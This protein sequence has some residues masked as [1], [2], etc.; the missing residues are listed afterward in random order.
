MQTEIMGRHK[1]IEYTAE[2]LLADALDPRA[3]A[4]LLASRV[5]ETG[6]WLDVLPI[7]SL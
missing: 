2:G 6:A 3:H 4:R 7:S 5:K 1:G